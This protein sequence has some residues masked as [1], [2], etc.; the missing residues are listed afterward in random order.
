M[1]KYSRRGD[2]MKVRHPDEKRIVETENL[3]ETSLI[4]HMITV[5]TDEENLTRMVVLNVFIETSM[6]ENL[7]NDCVLL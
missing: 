6:Y 3:K 2:W 7:V 4:K 1:K 5:L